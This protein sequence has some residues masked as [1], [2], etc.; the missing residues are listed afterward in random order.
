MNQ[1]FHYWSRVAT[2][3]PVETIRFVPVTHYDVSIKSGL[4]KI[5]NQLPY[6]VAIFWISISSAITGTNFVQIDHQLNELWKKTKRGPFLWNT[7][8][9]SI[10]NRTST[11][12]TVVP[13]ALKS[14]ELWSTN[15]GDLRV[16][17]YTPK[18]IFSG[19]HISS[20]KGAAPKI[21]YTR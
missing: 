9:R 5:F 4:A 11:T 21:F 20:P 14:G 1:I 16:E 15:Y 10:Q 12:S 8:Y 6:F 7:V 3:A 18:S 2:D 19:D 17:S 13:P